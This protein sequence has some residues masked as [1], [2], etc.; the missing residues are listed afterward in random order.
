MTVVGFYLTLTQLKVAND[1]S[2]AY[3]LSNVRPTSLPKM[4]WIEVVCDIS[5]VF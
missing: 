3:S 5:V 2:I 4:M 1:H